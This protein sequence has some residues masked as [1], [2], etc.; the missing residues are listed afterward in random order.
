MI[1][2]RL[3]PHALEAPLAPL[4]RDY[5]DLRAEGAACVLA[6]IVATAGS[7]YRKAGAQMLVTAGRQLRGL[8]SGGCLEVDLV[9]HAREVLLTG[10][11][12]LAS[13]DMRGEGDLLF[14]IGS[15]CE[16]A[17]QVLLERVG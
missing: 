6:T 4:A 16:G 10:N 17:V 8:L 5:R 15:G 1:G 12:R 7:T 9:E 2:L 11:A 3:M 13:Y 14:G